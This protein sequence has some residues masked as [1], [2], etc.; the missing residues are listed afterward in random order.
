MA[1]VDVG[2]R[3]ET[4][5]TSDQQARLRMLGVI[6]MN[7]SLLRGREGREGCAGS[8]GL[9]DTNC[10]IQSRQT[11]SPAGQHKELLYIPYPVL[12]H[13]GKEYKTK[14]LC[15][16]LS[17]SAVQ[18]KLVLNQ[19]YFNLKKEREW[20]NRSPRSPTQHDSISE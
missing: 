17:H 13:N 20:G 16:E 18:Q 15:V 6:A 19:L 8:L 4:R 9:V 14:C 2:K 12:K 7:L 5:D 1:L 3:E 10:Y 11:K